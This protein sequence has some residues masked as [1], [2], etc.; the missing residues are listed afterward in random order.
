MQLI[1]EVFTV[2]YKAATAH[3]KALMAAIKKVDK[4]V[5]IQVKEDNDEQSNLSDS[6]VLDKDIGINIGNIMQSIK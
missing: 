3:L 4:E 5:N 6:K 1:I 2:I